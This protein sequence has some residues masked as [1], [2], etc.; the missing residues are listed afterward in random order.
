M[1]NRL[2]FA[3]AFVTALFPAAGA[4]QSVF[5]HQIHLNKVGATCADC[6]TGAA[7]ST[8][9]T[10]SNLPPASACLKCHDG[11][12]A[13]KVDTGFLDKRQAP[14]RTYRFN[15]EF[16]S[17]MGNL[18][19]IIAAAID[20]RKYLGRVGEIR[21]HLETEN[22]CAACHRGLG[23]TDMATAANLPQMSDCLV[24]HNRIDNPFSC[25]KCHIEGVNLEPA[26]H[27][28]NF[29]DRHSTGKLGL[30]KTTCL[31]CHGKNFTCM[32]CH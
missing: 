2:P 25:E 28:D 7:S 4:G 29:L 1:R 27:I 3:V 24:C 22:A 15:H 11:E 31:P 18:A 9:A 32:G 26:S 12:R 23:E 19:P 16:H 5:S 30:D 20:D 13:K 17:Q 21:R 6:H 10:D 8:T 14:Q